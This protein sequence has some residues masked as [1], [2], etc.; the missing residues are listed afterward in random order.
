MM[1]EPNGMTAI[2]TLCLDCARLAPCA[3]PGHRFVAHP[4]LLS[5]AIAHIDCDAFYASVEKRDRPELA[6]LPVIVGSGQRGVVTT[7]C[8]IARLSGVASAMPMARARRL[9]PDAV[10]IAP[11]FN[12]YRTVSRQLRAM[13]GELT[14]LVQVLS[15]DEAVLDLR[16]TEALHRAP[17]A[18]VLARLARRVTHELG[19]PIS[20]GLAGNR[21][22]AKLAA[23]RGK[24]RGFCVLGTDALSWL[25][26]QPV[27]LLPG[28][29]AAQAR[30]L[31]ARGIA[32]LGQLQSLTDKAA[33]T[34]LGP[35]GP[36]LAAL[37]RGQDARPVRCE[38]VAR[39]V[40]TETT[41]ATDLTG[42]EPISRVLWQLCEMLAVRL[43]GAG[44]AAAGL[45]LKLKTA[46]FTV[47]T[48][49]RELSGPT[50]VPD[51]LF[52]AAC[53]LL[54]PELD[55]TAFRLV[56]V[57]ATRLVP[58]ALA[59]LG[60]LVDREA[61]KRAARQAA[62]DQLRGKFGDG[63]VRRGRGMGWNG[64]VL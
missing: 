41:F 18:V 28:V 53:D 29:G 22:L 52:E 35:E 57:G 16:G 55:G 5:L 10:V 27:T 13:L 64:G 62:V 33:Q 17:P 26:P 2:P 7:A 45:T 58:L 63:V 19:I 46:T 15:I 47:R 24:P 38:S 44:V 25:A 51:T 23:E 12:K 59:D 42:F 3:D 30:N 9:C 43:R 60:D 14:P 54:R 50:V 61:P 37:A 49:T 39:S 36:N 48:R 56:G 21:M 8:Y 40:R 31:A 20:I 6:A 34:L 4:E 11:N 1:P 32:R